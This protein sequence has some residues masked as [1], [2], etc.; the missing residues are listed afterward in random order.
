MRIAA[1]LLTILLAYILI[2]PYVEFDSE[3]LSGYVVLVTG[4]SRGSGRGFVHGLLEANAIVYV[5][6][7]TKRSLEETCETSKRPELCR[8]RI[9]DSSDDKDLEILFRNILETEGRLDI[10]VNNAYSGLSYWRKNELLGKPFW[11]TDV[12]MYD[13]IHDVGVRSHYKAS[14]LAVRV[15]RNQKGRGGLM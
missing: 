6:G 11:E 4:G 12:D 10:L 9:A 2:P 1:A 15:M 13:S 3:D 5:T 14:V 7:R 8:T